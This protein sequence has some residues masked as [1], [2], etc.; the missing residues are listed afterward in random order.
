MDGNERDL[1]EN[2]SNWIEYGR[3]LIEKQSNLIEN[4]SKLIENESKLIE[5]EPGPGKKL[6]DP[7]LFINRPIGVF[8]T[9]SVCASAVGGQFRSPKTFM[10]WSGLS[11]QSRHY[12]S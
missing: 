6:M 2:E 12:P 1:I 4:K 7:F 5:H 9:R 3:N 10:K 11:I 8:E